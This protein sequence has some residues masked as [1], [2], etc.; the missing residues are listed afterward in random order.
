MLCRGPGHGQGV[1]R[2]LVTG[3][4]APVVVLFMF[5]FGKRAETGCYGGWGGG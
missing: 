1:A 2:V 4:A 3:A 5:F